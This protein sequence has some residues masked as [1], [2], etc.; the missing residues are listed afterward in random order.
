MHAHSV[1][2]ERDADHKDVKEGGQSNGRMGHSTSDGPHS[3]KDRDR[4]RRGNS[5]DNRGDIGQSA[6]TAEV[7]TGDNSRKPATSRL[8]NPPA[9]GGNNDGLGQQG[10]PPRRENSRDD[11]GSAIK[12]AR[13]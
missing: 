5:R 8:G 1:K 4:D 10:A 13:R 3:S 7:A 12:R 9:V 2:R 11:G 6:V